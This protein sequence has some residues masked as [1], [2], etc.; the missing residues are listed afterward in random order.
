MFIV[1]AEADSKYLYRI[2]HET[3]VVTV[4]RGLLIQ[5]TVSS[6]FPGSTESTPRSTRSKKT[7]SVLSEDTRHSIFRPDSPMSVSTLGDGDSTVR[8]TPQSTARGTPQSTARNTPQSTARGTPQSTAR[9]TPRSTARGTPQ[10]T[11]RYSPRS[12]ARSV[13][14]SVADRISASAII[15]PR[16]DNYDTRRINNEFDTMISPTH[17]LDHRDMIY[18]SMTDSQSHERLRNGGTQARASTSS[19]KDLNATNNMLPQTLESRKPPKLELR[20]MQNSY[21]NPTYN[22]NKTPVNEVL[23]HFKTQISKNQAEDYIKKVNMAAC[24]IQNAFR[25]LVRRR[26]ALRASEAAMRR[27]LSQKRDDFNQK[28]E[29]DTQNSSRNKELERQRAREEKAKQAR[30]V[31]IEVSIDFFFLCYVFD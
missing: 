5:M 4:F 19:Q 29:Q 18:N 11:A 17:H 30:K 6:A 31:A 20:S 26:K 28:Q 14:S 13:S 25:K 21:Q 8:D 2:C 23:P 9:G 24:V 16:E 15:T 27:L 7:N 12:T 3:L 10:S 1:N 22:V